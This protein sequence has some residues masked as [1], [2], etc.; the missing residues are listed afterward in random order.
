MQIV[1]PHSEGEFIQFVKDTRWGPDV[2]PVKNINEATLYST[3]D[4]AEFSYR[5]DQVGYKVVF[6]PV[7]VTTTYKLNEN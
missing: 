5:V 2:F 6:R 4:D 7:V 1:G 3:L